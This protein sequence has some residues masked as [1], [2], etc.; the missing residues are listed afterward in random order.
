[1]TSRITYALTAA[2]LSIVSFSFLHFSAPAYAAG[3]TFYVSG[4][5]GNDAWSGLLPAPNATNTDGP[6]KTLGKA[7]SAIEGSAIKIATIRAGT[8]SLAGTI[9]TFNWWNDAGQT[10]V[11]YQN[12]SVIIDGGGTGY[13][14][15]NSTSNLTIEGLTFQNMGNDP[16][17]G[18]INIDGTGET[19][20]WNTF[21]N[22][23]SNCIGGHMSNST[24]DSNT[25]NGVSGGGW[26]GA[27]VLGYGASNNHITHNLIQ[28][29]VE[30]G[31]D[32]GTGSGDPP[33]NN[34]IIDSNIFRNT[35]SNTVDCGA[36]YMF[37][38]SHATTGNQITN[39][40]VNGNG[41][42]NYKT[43]Q[44]K[45]VYLDDSVSNVLV[46]GNICRNCG[47][48]GLQIHGGDHNT[49]TNN[50]FDL[51]STGTMLGLYQRSGIT[52]DFGMAGNVFKN[53]IVYFSGSVPASL[54]QVGI[55]SGDV[56]PTDSTNLYYSASG[57]K[58]PNSTIVD[59]NPVYANPQFTN[60]SAGDYSMPSNSPAYTQISFQP[61]PANQGPLSSPFTASDTTPPAI[62][63]IQASNVTTSSAAITWTTD[64]AAT[65]Q[66][67]Y[68]LTS[69]YGSTSLFNST[70]VTSH[71]QTLGSLAPSTLY[72]YRVDSKDASGNLAVSGDYT[73]TTGA[74]ST[75][76]SL[77]VPQGPFTA[78]YYSSTAG[79]KFQKLKL[80][81]TD[82]AISFA[83]GFGSPD[84]SLNVDNF[85]V[86]WT[87]TLNFP[88][89]GVYN[90]TAVTDDGMRVWI[91]NVL[92]LDKWFDQ[93][94]ATYTFSQS[95]PAGNH[96]IKVEYYEHL[97]TAVAKFSWSQAQVAAA[98]TSSFFFTRTLVKGSAYVSDVLALQRYLFTA[99][100]LPLA[101]TGYFGDLTEKA[102]KLFQQANH[103][104]PTGIVGAQTKHLLNALLNG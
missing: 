13:M 21:V 70:L 49:F 50:I 7:Q 103:L 78:Q 86:R 6:F 22:C 52:A 48:F 27:I 94:N 88:A 26:H 85:A 54:W 53:N 82:S 80:T 46:S 1:M 75:T 83:W 33:A 90:F 3:S 101:P 89:S 84:P 93:Y 29:V 65:S 32:I 39:N 81:R 45:A 44:T 62:S 24:I 97:N 9:W 17:G 34:N 58:I 31:I 71:S 30:E 67:E 51:S 56:L 79:N 76:T 19:I 10:W 102:V 68:G 16:S 63:N 96:A 100:L 91:D 66:G 61:L 8:Y 40:I 47:Q 55:S 11:P 14:H 64:E 25:I 87:G 77:P 20:R 4:T 43:D 69:S 38:A 2:V 37:D 12:E 23:A 35:C 18:G 74:V 15:G 99:S 36:I 28:N 60:A 92:V 57:A 95:L 59:T 5:N 98:E 42:V 73:F 72:H 41:G 104:P